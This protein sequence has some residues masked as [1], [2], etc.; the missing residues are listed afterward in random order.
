MTHWVEFSVNS[1]F[2]LHCVLNDT[3]NPV[4][5]PIVYTAT[6][7]T[8]HSVNITTT[9][10][11]HNVNITNSSHAVLYRVTNAGVD[12]RVNL[13]CITNSPFAMATLTYLVFVG[14]E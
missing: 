4:T 5:G 12:N 11:Q 8:Q 13:T 7:T 14:G 6:T 3:G 1:S 2:S 9:T 10:P